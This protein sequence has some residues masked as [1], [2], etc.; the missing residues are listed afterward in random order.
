M[1]RLPKSRGG[2]E[3]GVI[4][5]PGARVVWCRGELDISREKVVSDTVE[6]V[7]EKD[8]ESL[9]LHLRALTFTDCT[10]I[11]CIEHAVRACEGSGV[12][13]YVDAGPAVKKVADAL[14]PQMLGPVLG[15]L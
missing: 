4:D 8:I 14:E 3:I 11:R 5:I 1:K 12:P 15:R 13:I 6:R 2:F 10:A 9:V 7:L